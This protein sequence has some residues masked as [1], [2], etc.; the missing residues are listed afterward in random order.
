MALSENV[1][2]V[3][4][5]VDK[6]LIDKMDAICKAA[7]V[8]KSQLLAAFIED[9][10]EDFRV[11]GYLGVPHTRYEAVGRAIE[12]IVPM[13]SMC[14]QLMELIGEKVRKGKKG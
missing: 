7:N 9:G 6:G 13:N 14:Y 1:G 5:Y 11:L 3:A 4:A 10:L 12:K 8:S 2:R